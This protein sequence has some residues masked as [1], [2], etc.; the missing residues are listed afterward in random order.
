MKQ[1][2]PLLSLEI[3]TGKEGEKKTFPIGDFAQYLKLPASRA[4]LAG[5]RNEI[6]ALGT[7][8]NPMLRPV[9]ADYGQALALLARGKTS[10][11]RERLTRITM[12]DQGCMLR[13]YSR[14]IVDAINSCRELLPDPAF[15][16]ECIRS[17]WRELQQAAAKG[18]KSAAS[19][20]AS[21]AWAAAVNAAASSPPRAS[22]R[23]KISWAL[24][25][26]VPA[27]ASSP[28]PSSG[29]APNWNFADFGPPTLIRTGITCP[30][31]PRGAA[32]TTCGAA[33]PSRTTASRRRRY[34]CL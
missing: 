3:P 28:S 18:R 32:S 8:A 16:M 11:V 30:P 5:R 27:T 26:R 15:Y 6:V 24:R 23:R 20:L 2:T 25:R 1:L 17:S 19:R 31:A 10:G 21:S 33:S 14:E 29:S 22:A 13:A 7:R 4:A 9:L 34:A 12:T